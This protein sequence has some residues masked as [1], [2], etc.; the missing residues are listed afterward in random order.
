MKQMIDV[1]DEKDKVIG[2]ATIDEVHNKG[3]LHRAIHIF[4][5]NPEGKLFC[6]QRSLKKERY[7]GWWSTSV[8]AHVLSGQDYDQVAKQSLKDTLGIDCKLT[9]IGK[10]RVH[11][12]FENEI[13]ATYIGY[14]DEKM[15]FNPKQIEGGKFF[16]IQEIR[17][18]TKKKNVTP[19][20]AHS[21]NIY[22]RHK[23]E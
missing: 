4:I 3:L 8:G 1:V 19:H 21:L 13:S 23:D 15:D 2:K 22:L 10:A 18:L 7:P 9:F 6:R 14:S 17:E 5:I 20:L 11:D 12:K 16:S